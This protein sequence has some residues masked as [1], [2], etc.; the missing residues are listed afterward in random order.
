MQALV[1]SFPD[2]KDLKN[3]IDD[4]QTAYDGAASVA[5]L[6]ATMERG[7]IADFHRKAEQYYERIYQLDESVLGDI[8]VSLFKELDMKTRYAQSN[9]ESKQQMFE[10]MQQLCDIA[11]AVAFVNSASKKL[12]GAPPAM[13]HLISEI[14]QI[15]AVVADSAFDTFGE[16]VVNILPLVRNPESLVQSNPLMILAQIMQICA[17]ILATAPEAASNALK[18]RFLALAPQLAAAVQDQD[19]ASFLG[20]AFNVDTQEPVFASLKSTVQNAL[21][22]N[23]CSGSSTT[24]VASC[25]PTPL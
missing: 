23:S 10:R 6:Q 13:V 25:A 24:Q 1:A 14:K 9:T 21:G 17:P 19:F 2:D 20:N 7:F 4:Y 15:C 8:D 16:V 3:T 22:S 5:G 12:E 11:R 18:S